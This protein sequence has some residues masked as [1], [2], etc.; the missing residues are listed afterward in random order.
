VLI[1][2]PLTWVR[3]NCRQRGHRALSCFEVDFDPS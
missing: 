3:Q 2:S 1:S